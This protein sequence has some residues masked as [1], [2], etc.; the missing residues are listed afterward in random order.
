[1]LLANLCQIAPRDDVEPL[2]LFASV[3]IA[4]RPR[5]VDGYTEGVTGAV[6][7]EPFQDQPSRPMIRLFNPRSWASYFQHSSRRRGRSKARSSLRVELAFN[8][9]EPAPADGQKQHVL[10]SVS[11]LMDMLDGGGPDVG[12]RHVPP[13][14]VIQPLTFSTTR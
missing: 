14:L 9:P 4:G 10:A 11:L 6:G 13:A 2:R 7:R 3:A 12:L 5:A 1:M 8:R